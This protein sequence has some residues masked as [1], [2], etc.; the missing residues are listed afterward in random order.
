MIAIVAHVL[1]VMFSIRVWT[2]EN[3]SSDSFRIGRE[4]IGFRHELAVV[5]LCF[6][7]VA[8]NCSVGSFTSDVGNFG[9]G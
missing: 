2:F 4:R 6:E 3:L 9:F 1:S 5:D 8:R 7:V